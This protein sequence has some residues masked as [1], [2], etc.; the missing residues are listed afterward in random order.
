MKC[1]ECG[2]PRITSVSEDKQFCL[3]C[4]WDNLPELKTVPSLV[5]DLTINE[6]LI[7][8]VSEECDLTREEANI[9]IS[10]AVDRLDIGNNESE[11]RVTV[12]QLIDY[13]DENLELH[14]QSDNV[15]SVNE[16]T[17][18]VESFT[19]YWID[20]L[21]GHWLC[22]TPDVRTRVTDIHGDEIEMERYGHFYYSQTQKQLSNHGWINFAQIDGRIVEY[23]E[24]Q[25]ERHGSHFD[26]A[27]YLGE[28]EFHHTESA[29][30]SCSIYHEEMHQ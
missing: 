1:P 27:V 16:R 17:E 20:H 23:T 6:T 30:G 22:Q 11:D 10:R 21:T 12:N 24:W 18:G 8:R 2:S 29:G 4:E 5:G 3:D 15:L 14:S 28:G 25:E 7:T 19:G 26:D 13:I 9:A